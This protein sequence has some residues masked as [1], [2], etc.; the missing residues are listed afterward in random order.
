MGWAGCGGGASTTGNPDAAGTGGSNGGT[1]SAGGSGGTSAS[2]GGTTG[3]AG[4]AGSAGARGGA[5]GSGGTGGSAGAAGSGGA[6]TGA[7]GGAGGTAGS[8]GRGGAGGSAGSAGRGG[9]T[10]AGGMAGAGGAAAPTCKRGIAANTA[11]GAA[12]YPAVRWWYNWGLSKS[13]GNT[14]IEFV[15]MVWGSST[16]NGAI[17][18]GSKYLLGFNEPNFMAQSNLTPQAAATA[19]PAL[20]TNARSAGIGTIVGPGMNFCGP[21]ASCNG[22]D[23]YVY[24]TD[25]LADCTTCEVDHIAV[26]WYNCDLPSLKA[27]IESNNSLAGWVQFGKPIWVTEFSCDGSATAAQQEAYMRAAIP[28]LE[29]QPNVFRYSWFSAGPIPNAQLINSDGSPTALG[30]VYISLPSNCQ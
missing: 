19:W 18:A 22:T 16:V 9:T 15:P 28:Y 1:T 10:G 20:Q 26:H 8:A 24:L 12:F 7:R 6:G 25:F 11:P 30:Q 17:P 5:G 21:A 3:T 23:P 4:A 29:S 27:Y 2:R 14:G 13:G